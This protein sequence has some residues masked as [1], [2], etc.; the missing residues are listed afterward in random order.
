MVIS[1]RQS[2]MR[3]RTT[4]FFVFFW[5]AALW[6][7]ATATQIE[8]VS[9]RQMG[10][11]SALVVRGKVASVRSF[12]NDAH[13]KIF[14]ETVVQVDETYKGGVVGSARIIQLGGVVDHMRVHVHG[15]L[16][17]HRGEEI[18]LFLDR[19]DGDQFRVAGFSQGKFNI[20]RDPVTGKAFIRRPADE[21]AEIQGAPPPGREGPFAQTSSVPLDEFVNHALG[22]K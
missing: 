13:T 11:E 21:G 3:K 12:W 1:R 17:W 10:D 14:T 18:L 15:A 19:I 20:E 5:A 22:R 7:N 2:L 16:E 9:P 8:Y 4:A 6:S